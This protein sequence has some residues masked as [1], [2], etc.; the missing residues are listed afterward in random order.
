MKPDDERRILKLTQRFDELARLA[1][2]HHDVT[3]PSKAPRARF[4]NPSS[5]INCGF[6]GFFIGMGITQILLLGVWPAVIALC[7]GLLMFWY[8]IFEG[9]RSH[10]NEES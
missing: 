10:H 6:G 8:G 2:P 9:G 1:E 4:F 5:H 3:E 7:Y